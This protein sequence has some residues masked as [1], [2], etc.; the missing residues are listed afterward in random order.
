MG[1]DSQEVIR[2]DNR[3]LKLSLS[4]LVFLMPVTCC[5]QSK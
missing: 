4:N 2:V 1:E 3:R 5:N